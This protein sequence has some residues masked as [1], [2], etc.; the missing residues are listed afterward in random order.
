MYIARR[1]VVYNLTHLKARLK[2]K[3][4]NATDKNFPQFFSEDRPTNQ[5]TNQPTNRPTD[6][7]TQWDREAPS[8]SLK[9]RNEWIFPKENRENFCEIAK[10]LYKLNIWPPAW[11]IAFYLPVCKA[12]LSTSS[13]ALKLDLKKSTPVRWAGSPAGFDLHLGSH[14]VHP[15]LLPHFW[16]GISPFPVMV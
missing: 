7:P 10:I 15:L 12:S 16:F 5:P 1:L 2:L 3:I 6:R 11:M 4:W 8:R 13:L 9:T 14:R